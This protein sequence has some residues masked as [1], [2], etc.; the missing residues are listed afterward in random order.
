MRGQRRAGGRAGKG[1]AGREGKVRRGAKGYGKGDRGEGEWGSPTHNFRLKSCTAEV[2][3]LSVTVN[4]D[5]NKTVL[6][7]TKTHTE[8][9]NNCLKAV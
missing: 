1:E 9:T 6:S 2:P 3:G 5:V 4:N 8:H 7:Q